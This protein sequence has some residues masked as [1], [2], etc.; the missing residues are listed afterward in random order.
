MVLLDHSEHHYIN[1]GRLTFTH[2]SA[3]VTFLMG[4]CFHS[5]IHSTAQGVHVECAS[6]AA[7][8]HAATVHGS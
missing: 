2:Y 3:T 1:D 7:T 8:A 6:N 4:T 5:V